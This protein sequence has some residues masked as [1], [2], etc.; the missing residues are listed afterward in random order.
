[1][2][3]EV[4]NSSGKHYKTINT[5]ADDVGMTPNAIQHALRS[6]SRCGGVYWAKKGEKLP[7]VLPVPTPEEYQAKRE[8]NLAKMATDKKVIK[9]P[10]C[11]PRTQ[12]D[13]CKS[14]NCPYYCKEEKQK[15]NPIVFDIAR[16]HKGEITMERA[17]ELLLRN[18][19]TSAFTQGRPVHNVTLGIVYRSGVAAVD[20]LNAMTGRVY[21]SQMIH[22]VATQKKGKLCGM[23]FEYVEL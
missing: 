23:K 2:A 17:H 5:A 14:R 9:C 12:T 18:E 8:E 22:T 6:G 1:M 20:A 3:I 15:N 4:Y 11:E 19:Q 16:P 21:H 7:N 10:V 13:W